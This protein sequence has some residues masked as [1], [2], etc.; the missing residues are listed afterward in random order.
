MK[1]V[2]LL[3]NYRHFMLLGLL[4]LI[5]ILGFY[6]LSSIYAL[7]SIDSRTVVLNSSQFNTSLTSRNTEAFEIK[8]VTKLTNSYPIFDLQVQ[9]HNKVILNVPDHSVSGFKIAM[10]HLDNNQLSVIAENVEYEITLTPDAKQ[11]I[12]SKLGNGWESLGTNVYSLELNKDLKQLRDNNSYSKFFIDHERYLGLSGSDII[13]TN[14]STGEIQQLITYD[15]LLELIGTATGSSNLNEITI[16]WD[17]IQKAG[18]NKVYFLADLN[19]SFGIFEMDLKNTSKVKLVTSGKEINQ[20][21]VMN[22]GDLV[23]QGKIN[24]TDGLFLYNQEAGQF[25]LLK[26]GIITNYAM[27]SDESRIAYF[28]LNSNQTGDLHAAYLDNG[29]LDSDT[30]IYQ[31]IQSVQTMKWHEDDLFVTGSQ[32]S[33]SEIYRFTF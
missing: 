9:D 23:L 12:Y 22:N 19:S 29:S 28:M 30:V 3:G 25:K 2:S 7:S 24:N 32:L 8:A 16:R 14:I 1:K 33:K 26:E 17:I 4:L 27:Q 13:L 15:Q 6:G 18:Q 11:L 31:N 20:F 5:F 10:L 21:L